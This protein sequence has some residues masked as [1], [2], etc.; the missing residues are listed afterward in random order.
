M[1]GGAFRVD[2]IANRLFQA[3]ALIDHGTSCYAT[4]SSSF[5]EKAGLPRIEIT[6]RALEGVTPDHAGVI[7]EVTYMSI[8]ID[9][10]IQERV[11]LYVIPHQVEDVILG[12]RW[13][14]SEG[15][16]LKPREGV[17]EI[18]SSGAAIMARD[19]K[20][21]GQMNRPYRVPAAAMATY[22]EEAHRDG[23]AASVRVFAA[24]LKDIERALQQ[25]TKSDP[26]E[27]LPP[28]YR[29]FLP[30]FQGGDANQL[31]PH[32]P[33]IDM[34]IVLEKDKDGRDKEPPWGPL[35]SM[36]R[37]ELLVLRK[38]I[39]DLLDKGFIRVSHSPAAAP[40]LFAKKPSG[41]LRF[42]VDYRALNAIT[43]K[44]RYPLPLIQET[45][46]QVSQA[47]WFT[48]LDVQAAFHKLRV[49]EGE[50]WKT[51]FRTRYGLFEWLVTP[52]GLANGPSQFQRYINWVLRE[53]LDTYVSA[54]VD[55][56]LIYTAGTL[57]DH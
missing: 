12:L 5:A 2:M 11:F 6:P 8:D 3:T 13:I 45:L 49:A 57:E 32:R 47:K 39:M 31:P 29:E 56:V 35:Y 50:E 54:Y 43:T 18:E 15:A 42:C 46:R 34:K 19:Y 22:L 21:D 14:Q 25:K 1:D 33:G 51:A 24:S 4:V 10:H 20:K 7:R 53:L 17:L 36:S 55:D 41:G 26:A 48:K 27:R 23:D 30:V 44:D 28:Q 16:V 52:F 40:V 38:T 37:D 9:G